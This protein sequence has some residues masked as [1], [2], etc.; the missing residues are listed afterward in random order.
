MKDR[1]SLPMKD[2]IQDPEVAQA[3]DT[4]ERHGVTKRY[5]DEQMIRRPTTIRSRKPETSEG[6]NGDIDF[7]QEG[8]D[9]FMVAKI[10]GKWYKINKLEEI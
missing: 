2:S 4:I 1:I 8:A 5:V 10:N 9:V 3:M 7:L 6:S